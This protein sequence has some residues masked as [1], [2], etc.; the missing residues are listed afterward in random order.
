MG[1]TKVAEED[2]AG[3]TSAAGTRGAAA[4][5]P[6]EFGVVWLLFVVVAV[7]M[8]V[9]YARL[10]AR[11]LYHVS[12]T[13]FAG[14]ASRVLV[15]SNFSTALVAI[16][17]LAVLADRM[18]DRLSAGAAVVGIVFSAAVFWP[19][20]IDQANLDAKPVNAVAAVG[21]LVAGALS[22][23]AVRKLGRPVWSGRQSGDRVRVVVAAAA[24]V[25]GLPWFAAEL[26][27]FLNGVPLLGWLFQTGKYLPTVPGLPPF[28]PAVHHGHH[29]GMDGVLLLLSALLLSRVVPS[30]RRRRLRLGV[31]AYLALMACYAVGNI[32]NDFWLEQVWKRRWTSWEIPDVL[33]PTVTVAWGLIVVGAAAVYAASVWWTNR[34]SRRR[35]GLGFPGTRGEER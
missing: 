10:P 11:E 16:P 22:V 29:H 15:F 18:P 32:A 9:T 19:G 35:I 7:E 27:F 33:R 24:L 3:T 1:T 8:F 6:L 4:S 30:V 25:V 20:V 34:Q 12:H 23:L 26:G 21:V 14:G 2:Q 28:P 5:V 13:G 31:G 17:L